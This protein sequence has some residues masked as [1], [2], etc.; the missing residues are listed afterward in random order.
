MRKRDSSPLYTRMGRSPTSA[1]RPPISE[2]PGSSVG[3]LV[4]TQ[5]TPTSDSGKGSVSSVQP[6]PSASTAVMR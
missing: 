4:T 2:S 1:V 6:L 5:C 3:A